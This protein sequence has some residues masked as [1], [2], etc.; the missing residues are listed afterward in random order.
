MFGGANDCEGL[1][2]PEHETLIYSPACAQHLQRDTLTDCCAHGDSLVRW[3]LHAVVPIALMLLVLGL[4]LDS[5]AVVLCAALLVGLGVAGC[6]PCS[7]PALFLVVVAY[8]WLQIGEK[9]YFIVMH[10][11]FVS[12]QTSHAR[13]LRVNMLLNV[14]SALP[15]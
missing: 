1:S 8:M 3:C 4:Y 9:A 11:N 7:T 13:P 6:M 10:S 14:S 12:N 2:V 5:I 15:P